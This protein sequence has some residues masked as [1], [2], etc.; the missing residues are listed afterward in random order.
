MKPMGA[1]VREVQINGQRCRLGVYSDLGDE[2][3]ACAYLR[4]RQ[5]GL[6]SV[7]YYL[8]DPTLREFLDWHR[9]PRNI[10]LGAFHTPIFASGE[11]GAV[12]LAGIGWLNSITDLGSHR[13]AEVGMIYFREFWGNG[14][15][16]EWTEMMLDFA[17]QEA[18]IGVVYGCTPTQNPLARRFAKA[19]GMREFGPVP[20]YCAWR[21]Q[22]SDAWFFSLTK[23]EWY[24]RS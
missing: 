21:G 10:Y 19:L 23:E 17:F 16:M 9:N 13:K 11:E 14:L 6:L 2:L 7:V 8:G 4:M 24:G 22:P 3:L 5:E 12:Q 1:P 20:K 15:P 18:G